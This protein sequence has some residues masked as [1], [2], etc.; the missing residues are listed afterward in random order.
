MDC[1]QR[2]LDYYEYS[3]LSPSMRA[4]EELT[5][6]DMEFLIPQ[7]DRQGYIDLAQFLSFSVL[8][9][10]F[11][12]EV[13]RKGGESVLKGAKQALDYVKGDKTQGRRTNEHN[14]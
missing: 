9:F 1:D 2:L 11:Y 14:K 13:V 4:A 6:E 7:E 3:K 12:S 10:V 5:K 8:G